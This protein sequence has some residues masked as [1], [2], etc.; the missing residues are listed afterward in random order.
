MENP[1]DI[2]R[3]PYEALGAK[4]PKDAIQSVS[5]GVTDH[6]IYVG[7]M[8]NRP[9]P[10]DVVTCT[11][12]RIGRVLVTGY[13]REGGYVGITGE[14]IDPP[15]WFRNQNGKDWSLSLFPSEFKIAETAL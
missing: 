15:E 5:P 9:V 7:D 13:F 12:N 11:V 1:N 8:A 2:R 3:A 4:F 6:W 10:G 14:A